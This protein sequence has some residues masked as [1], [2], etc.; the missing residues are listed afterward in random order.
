MQELIQELIEEIKRLTEQLQDQN[1]Q[2]E[3][4]SEQLAALRKEIAEKDAL[5]VALTKRIE[6]LTHRK[7]SGNSSVPPSKDGYHKPA[8]KSLR[9][10][11]GKKTGRTGR[12]QGEGNENRP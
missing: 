12:T 1:G 8:P 5:I 10:K 11:S 6:E 2:L 7:N 4:Q 9:E 3:R